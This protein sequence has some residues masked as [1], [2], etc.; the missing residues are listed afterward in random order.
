[1]AEDATKDLTIGSPFKLV[2]DFS[3]PILFG[4]LFQQFYNLVDTIIVGRV[5][6]VNALAAVGVTGSV[7]F[8][9]LGFCIGV[10]SGFA[11]PVAQRFGAKDYAG[12]RRAVANSTWLCILFAMVMTIVTSL[13]CR[14]ILEWM[15][16]PSDIIDDAY[17]YLLIVFISIP[18]IYLYNMLSGIIRS[19]GDSKTPVVFLVIASILNIILDYTLMVPIKLGVAGASLATLIS[20]AISGICCLFYMKKKFQILKISKSEWRMD[21]HCMGV[22]C[23]MGIPMGLQYSITAIGS[24]ILQT[25]VNGLGA[26]SVAAMTAGNKISMFF[27]CP[28][29]ALGTTMATFSGQNVGAKR[30]DRVGE[31][32][33]AGNIIGAVYSAMAF[34]V[35]YLFSNELAL[36]FVNKGEEYILDEV[37]MV[38]LFNS[39]FYIS[40]SVLNNTRFLIQGMGFSR[41][42]IFAGVLEMIA[43]SVVGFLFVPRFGFKAACLA[44]PIA[45]TMADMFLIPAYFMVKKK[46]QRIFEGETQ[47]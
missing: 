17:S 46:L 23:G 29:D 21:A 4:F 1:M 24:V 34:V 40:L 31:G 11:I 39:I 20:Q 9:I 25:A 15:K 45:W 2:L 41:L 37:V 32:L 13:L 16:T 28:Y 43:R 30:L 44:G 38:L 18:V 14:Q 27:S 10:C 5:L 47:V 22:L 42:A 3:I 33:R 26:A 12:M 36:L 19:L 35:L 6:G 7:C 8:M